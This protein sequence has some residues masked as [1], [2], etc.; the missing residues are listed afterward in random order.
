M[1][2]EISKVDEPILDLKDEPPKDEHVII[3]KAKIDEI[4]SPEVKKRKKKEGMLSKQE[5]RYI[6]TRS[7]FSKKYQ[8]VMK[9]RV[10]RRIEGMV[11]D[12]LFC[13][14]Y[15]EVIDKELLAPIEKLTGKV[16]KKDEVPEDHSKKESVEDDPQ[17]R[18]I[19][20]DGEAEF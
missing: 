15:Q 5:K 2:E 1:I 6:K 17:G 19:A 16:L 12:L 14:E 4:V 7:S 18:K 10:K 20:D 3:D 8:R 13:L 11:K 9:G